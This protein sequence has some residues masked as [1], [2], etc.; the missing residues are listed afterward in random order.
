MSGTPTISIYESTFAK[1]DKTDAILFVDEKKL[2]VNRALLSYHSDYFE[3][4]FNTDSEEKSPPEFPIPD[5]NFEHFATVLSLVQ[6]NP[7]ENNDNDFENLLELT[8][9]FQL[10]AA[11]RYLE[12]Q[13]I[14]TSSI[15]KKSKI[16]IADK[17]K[18]HELFN[19]SLLDSKND[20][21]KITPPSR[22]NFHTSS[23][24]PRYTYFKTLSNESNIKLFH[25]LVKIMHG[26]CVK[27]AQYE[28]E[29][30]YESAFAESDKTDAI[31]AVGEKKLHVNKAPSAGPI[32]DVKFEVFAALLSLVHRYPIF[33]TENNVE[34]LLELADRFLLLPSV[35]RTLEQFLIS[36]KIDSPNKLR[37]ADKYKLDELLSNAINSFRD[38]SSCN[39]L[40]MLPFYQSI[41]DETKVKLFH[42]M[43]FYVR[44]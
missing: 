36:T 25:Q 20:Y 16:E 26:S 19:N 44:E 31:L 21:S 41:S 24:S 42:H 1:S 23:S 11:K 39:D 33:P 18:L 14:F 5:V 9:R 22:G 38:F 13:L 15:P 2:H 8:E 3:T 30:T 27:S 32:E 34:N 4:L 43:L 35:K 28:L 6:N 12:F 17:F 37:I 10:S 29:N 40:T 7:I